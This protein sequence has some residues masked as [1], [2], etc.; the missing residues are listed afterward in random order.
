MD[1]FLKEYEAEPDAIDF[2]F[3]PVDTA[4]EDKMRA[5]VETKY[6]PEVHG[7]PEMSITYNGPTIRVRVS[8]DYQASQKRL[9][10]DVTVEVEAPTP[11]DIADMRASTLAARAIAVG[12][13]TVAFR[14]VQK[15]IADQ[16][17]E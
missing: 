9:V 6:E 4:S 11:D 8:A 2:G 10:P 5:D 14:Q 1:T 7:G 16:K 15:V 13:F 12:E 3:G 17:G